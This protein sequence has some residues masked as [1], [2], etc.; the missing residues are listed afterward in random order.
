VIAALALAT[1]L[2]GPAQAAP[3][4]APTRLDNLSAVDLFALADRARAAGK[5]AE[6]IVLYDAL[7]RDPN[8]EI[9][10]EARFRKGMA[11]ADAKRWRE[12]A[13][14]FRG[15]LD[16]QPGATRVR[17]ELARVLAALGDESA[18]RREVRQAQ[19]A[20]LPDDVALTVDQFARALRSPKTLGG[21]IEVA[22]APDSNI[23]R[24]T[25]ARTLDTV[26]A[27]LTLS[28]DARARD[29]ASGCR[30]RALRGSR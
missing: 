19:A 30:A 15:L 9:R 10:A 25:A 14:A 1:A 24:A 28:R 3:G 7:A 20:G 21:S 23:N 13:L 8:A 2:P 17:L 22:L 12:A 11:L 18:A 6:A 5:V 16:E 27:P 26:I 4:P 29:S